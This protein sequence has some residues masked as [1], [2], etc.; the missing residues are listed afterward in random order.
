MNVVTV[1]KEGLP[2][3]SLFLFLCLKHI[4]LLSLLIVSH[5]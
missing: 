1:M 4:A 2:S 3:G 5:G